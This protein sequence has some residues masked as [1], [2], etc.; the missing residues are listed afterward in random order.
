MSTTTFISVRKASTLSFVTAF[1]ILAMQ[2]LVARIVSAK[3]LNNYAFFI[4]SL[5]MLGFAFSG[6]ILSRWLAKFAERPGECLNWCCALSVISTLVV[7]VLFYQ[8]GIGPQKFGSRG[9]FVESF[10]KLMPFA[11]LYA[12]PFAFSGFILGLLLTLP[13]LPTRRIYCFDLVGSSCGALA[14]LP[15]ISAWGVE[16]GLLVLCGAQWAAGAL[17]VPARSWRARVMMGAALFSIIAAVLFG[18]S[19]FEMRHRDDSVLA[20]AQRPGTG[21]VLEHTSWDP[22]ARIEVTR[23]PPPDPETSAFPALI[24]D[25]RTF[26]KRF[27]KVITQN[28][29][30]FTY[31]VSYDGNRQSLAGIDQTIYAAAYQARSIANPKVAIIGVGG[32]FDVLTALYFEAATVTGVEINSA[33]VKILKRT[34]H[35]YFKAWVDDPRVRLVQGEGRHFLASGDERFDVLQLSGVDSYSGTPGAANVFSENYLYTAEA[36]DLYLSRLTD[37]GILNMMRLEHRPPREMLR[38]LITAV[39]ALRRA[40]ISDPANHIMMVSSKEGNFVSMLVKRTP[41]TE[42]EER[43]VTDWVAGNKLLRLAVAP[44]WNPS[45]KNFYQQFLALNDPAAEEAYFGICPFNVVPATDDKPFFFRFSYWWHLPTRNPLILL[46]PPVL[47]ISLSLLAVLIGSIAVICVWLPLRSQLTSP[48]SGMARW[49]YGLTLALTATGYMGIEIALLQK[50]GLFLGHPNYALSV[51]LAAML[52]ATG[53]G[54]LASDVIV[55]ALGGV[56]MASFVLAGCLLVEYVF[57][58]PHLTNWVVLPFGLRVT[59]VSVLVSPPA[60]LMGTF[61]PTALD[62]LK[63]SGNGEFIPWAWGINGIFS[64]LAPVLSIALSVTAGISVLLLSGI[65][66][67]L[68]VGLVFPLTASSDAKPEDSATESTDVVLIEG[69]RV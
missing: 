45:E 1:V 44:R 2:V 30:A 27:E 54:S 8:V 4:I 43:G 13:E 63:A 50:F 66:I 22:V 34:Y 58:L 23:I 53:I 55:R 15:A 29:Y 33:T 57:L 7:T 56:K 6:V 26:L 20:T 11:L 61:V 49:R 47:E 10:L 69:V 16:R 52:L 31:G 35:E 9:E 28:N 65:A 68:V 36:F 39:A 17:L 5:T 40:G 21:F 38:A 59:L 25:N 37:N 12:I 64:V 18:N 60:T 32:G 19:I 62:R 51:V 24:G 67:Y 48:G 42:T 41:F 14:V 46:L 3:L